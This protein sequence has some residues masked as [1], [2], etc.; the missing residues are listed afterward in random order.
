MDRKLLG[1]SAGNYHGCYASNKAEKFKFRRVSMG[2]DSCA[3]AQAMKH[4]KEERKF[5]AMYQNLQKERRKHEIKSTTSPGPSHGL[6]KSAATVPEPS[7]NVRDYSKDVSCFFPFYAKVTDIALENDVPHSPV[8]TTRADLQ[9]IQRKA[10]RHV[11]LNS[12]SNYPATVP[13]YLQSSYTR[14]RYDPRYDP[15]SKGPNGVENVAQTSEQFVRKKATGFPTFQGGGVTIPPNLQSIEEKPD[16]MGVSGSNT[17]LYSIAPLKKATKRPSIPKTNSTHLP[18]VATTQN[19]FNS[20]LTSI[21]RKELARYNDIRVTSLNANPTAE[22]ASKAKQ[23]LESE[24]LR[25]ASQSF[26][27]D[28][29]P[30]NININLSSRVSEEV[31]LLN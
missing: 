25:N 11:S 28:S 7:V 16:E 3:Q 24:K 15:P 8:K 5:H 26:A 19:V 13:F 9:R 22:R 6:N 20:I 10:T 18:H 1:T 21:E 4:R 2:L 23:H 27:I 30:K 14:Y 17:T 29:H 12:D 31:I